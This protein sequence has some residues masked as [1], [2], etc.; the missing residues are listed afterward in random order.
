M[1]PAQLSRPASSPM[2]I[3]PDAGSNGAG[4]ASP[5]R[6][7][8]SC[9]WPPVSGLWSWP[10]RMHQALWTLSSCSRLSAGARGNTYGCRRLVCY[11]MP[12]IRLPFLPG[13]PEDQA[14]MPVGMQ[15]APGATVGRARTPVAAGADMPDQSHHPRPA[16]PQHTVTTNPAR[17]GPV[18][19]THYPSRLRRLPH[20]HSRYAVRSSISPRCPAWKPPSGSSPFR[21]PSAVVHHLAQCQNSFHNPSSA[22][23][24]RPPAGHP[25]AWP[26]CQQGSPG[27]HAALRVVGQPWAYA[28]ALVTKYTST[29]LPTACSAC[30]AT[31]P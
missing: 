16:G 21:S 12:A 15:S 26:R 1:Y 28:V 11:P 2:P 9:Q 20:R 17:A 4:G 31:E 19:L 7:S 27:G 30:L 6:C 5:T 8:H 29:G 23:G 25:R 10:H 24:F 14:T 3:T 13:L 22:T 18:V